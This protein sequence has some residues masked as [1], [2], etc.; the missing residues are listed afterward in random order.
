MSRRIINEAVKLHQEAELALVSFGKALTQRHR[1]YGK[2][3][4][5]SIKKWNKFQKIAEKASDEDLRHIIKETGIDKT[6]RYAYGPEL[7]ERIKE[8]TQK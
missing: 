5:A 1:R 7:W 4:N 2:W 8:V 3:L 6:Q